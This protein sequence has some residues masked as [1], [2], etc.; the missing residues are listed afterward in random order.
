MSSRRNSWR[1]PLLAVLLTSLAGCADYANHR[2]TVTLAAGDAVAANAA[3]QTIDP[4]PRGAE[5]TVILADGRR[6]RVIIDRFGR[7][8]PIGTLPPSTVPTITAAG[9]Q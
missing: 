3:I 8:L 9:A 1:L 7:M 2:D 6:I 4:W 5:R